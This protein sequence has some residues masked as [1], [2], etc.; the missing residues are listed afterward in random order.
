MKDM[1]V[2]RTVSLSEEEMKEV[3]GGDAKYSPSCQQLPGGADCGGECAPL[4]KN[5][6][7]IPQKCKKIG[8]LDL[9]FVVCDCG[10]Y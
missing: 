5:G 1:N 7:L 4:F 9:G 8:E 2:K 6:K 3:L 10:N